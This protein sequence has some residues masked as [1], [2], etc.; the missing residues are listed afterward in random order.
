VWDNTD[1]EV[2]R[3]Q[4]LWRLFIELVGR[5]TSFRK[6]GTVDYTGIASVRGPE[7]FR[8]PVYRQPQA[9]G[10]PLGY[11]EAGRYAP[12]FRA[13]ASR[14]WLEVTLPGGDKGWLRNDPDHVVVRVPDPELVTIVVDPGHGGS[15]TGAVANGIVEKEYN[16]DIAYWHLATRL[17]NNPRIHRIWLTRNGDETVSLAYRSDLANAAGAHLFVSVHLNSHLTTSRG[18]E[19]YYKCGS[20]AGDPVR[21]ASKRAACLV[22]HRVKYW[23]EAWNSP[24]CPWFD[25]GVICRLISTTDRRSYYYV[26]RNTQIPAVLCE[27]LFISNPNEAHCLKDHTFRDN[28]AQATYEG[29]IE[30]L[31]G[32]DPGTGCTFKTFY[33]L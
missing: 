5:L 24:S 3:M 18:T 2:T 14:T 8:M 26:L 16:F 19:T 31:F 10:Q 28:L 15:D 4:T 27:Y 6:Q 11:L 33:G 13:T 1:G 12:H 23:I 20:E 32:T 17:Q 9:T 30:F 22:H 29:I 25:R 7:G 21:E